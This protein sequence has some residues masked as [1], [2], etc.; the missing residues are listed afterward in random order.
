MALKT[1]CVS[2][3]AH[4]SRDKRL[5]AEQQRKPKKDERRAADAELRPPLPPPAAHQ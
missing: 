5:L 3:Q 2:V 1:D 4:K